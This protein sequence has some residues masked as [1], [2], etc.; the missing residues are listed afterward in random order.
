VWR[1]I[2]QG[3]SGS[4]YAVALRMLLDEHEAQ[5]AVQETFLK[6]FRARRQLRDTRTIGGWLRQI[7]IRHCLDKPPRPRADEQD[8]TWA[9]VSDTSE[10]S[11]QS[12]AA[13]RQ[14]L[15]RTLAAVESLPPRQR[16]C[17]VLTVFEQMNAREI[18]DA[19]GISHGAVRRYLHEA[20]QR[21]VEI[22]SE[23]RA[24]ART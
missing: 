17:L 11:P 19:M 6:A 5:D 21:L 1:S 13:S 2:V 24:E 8:R 12:Q 10:A 7:L 4:L 23:P 22:T 14:E 9:F 20:R 16:A 3:F 18:A 15:D